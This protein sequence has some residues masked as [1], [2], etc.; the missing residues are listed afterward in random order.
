MEAIVRKMEIKDLDD[1]VLIEEISFPTP[2]SKSAF[3]KELKKNLLAKYLVVTLEEKVV[4]FG[5]MWLIVDEAHVTNI[6]VHPDYR[7][8]Q[9]GKLLVEGMIKEAHSIGMLRMTLEVRRSN[10]VAQNLY[11]ALGFLFCGVRPGYYQDNGED[12]IIMW[13]DIE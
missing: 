6:A 5:G 12:A 4:A 13:R 8:K 10:I 3:E 9:L 11:K 2:W 1:V 7:G